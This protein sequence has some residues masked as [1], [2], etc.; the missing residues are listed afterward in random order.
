VKDTTSRLGPEIAENPIEIVT[1]PSESA[2][3]RVVEI[4]ERELGGYSRTIATTLVADGAPWAEAEQAFMAMAGDH[5]LMILAKTELGTLTTLSGKRKRCA[6]Y[7][8][9]DPL[10]ANQLFEIDV[11]ASFYFPFRIAI[12]GG[13]TV[14]RAHIAFDRPSAALRALNNAA[15]DDIGNEL[16]ARFSRVIELIRQEI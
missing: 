11:L 4:F 12:F 16:D 6:L 9:G 7:L 5:G 10:V 2:Y 13:R 3:E 14:D 15:F 1:A 8:V